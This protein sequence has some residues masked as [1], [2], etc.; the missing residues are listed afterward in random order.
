[1]DKLPAY[2]LQAVNEYK[3]VEVDG[4]MFYP[5]KVRQYEQFLIARQ[6]IGFMAQ[7][8]PIEL[9]SMPL[10]SAL[11]LTDYTMAVGG[12]TPTGLFTSALVALAYSLRLTDD[13]VSIEQ[14]CSNFELVTEPDDQSRLKALRFIINGEEIHEITPIQFARIRQVIAAQNGIEIIDEDANPELVQA[15][16]D[17][18][19]AKALKLKMSQ[20]DMV[21]SIAALTN[22]DDAEIY[23]WPVLKL[24]NRMQAFKRVLDYM[25]CGIGE[26]QGTKWKG[27]NPCPN[28]WFDRIKEGSSS[29]I[30][31]EQFAG[32]QT[33][34][35][36]L[37]GEAARHL[38]ELSDET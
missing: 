21:H 33:A 36:V 13:N 10:L 14:A 19:E 29:L 11:F 9:M 4:L 17:L 20:H 25:I 32:G 7:Q 26:S 37:A 8:L 23:D 12:E 34:Q 16:Q 27:G 3:P 18:A 24:H 28:P 5:F 31:I 2:I 30:G 1:M 38:D 22:T 35:T 15:E 6:S